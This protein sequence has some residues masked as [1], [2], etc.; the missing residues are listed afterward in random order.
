[1]YLCFIT[2]RST[3]KPSV[4]RV[5]G[6]PVDAEGGPRGWMSDMPLL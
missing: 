6:S 3:L 2:L 4:L 1:M 5:A